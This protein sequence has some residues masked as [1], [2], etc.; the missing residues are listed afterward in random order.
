[1]RGRKG[2]C[3]Y[4]SLSHNHAPADFDATIAVKQ[5]WLRLYRFYECEFSALRREVVALRP[6]RDCT[7]SFS[8]V[9]QQRLRTGRLE[10]RD[11]DRLHVGFAK[12]NNAPIHI[13]ETPALTAIELNARARRLWSQYGGLGLIVVHCLQ[14]MFASTSVENRTHEISEITRS[15]KALAKELKAPIVA[16]SQLNRL[17]EYRLNKR[18]VT[19]DL[20]DSGAIEQDADV[21]LFIVRDEVYDPETADKGA[22]EIIIAKQRNGPIGTVRLNFVGQNTKFE[23]YQDAV[24]E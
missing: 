22:A 4:L 11:W 23:N 8:K 3:N 13:D 20:R 12:L 9:D 1:M 15:L 7:R 21:I 10:T 6:N 2:N 16:L 5:G 18:P 24:V 17:V 19:S 14:L